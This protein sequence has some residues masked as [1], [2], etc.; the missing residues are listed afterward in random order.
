MPASREAAEAAAAPLA[1]GSCMGAERQKVTE[2]MGPG[3][4]RLRGHGEDCSL[5][6]GRGM[7]HSALCLS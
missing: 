6:N 7:I 4:A 1:E 2:V 3:H 5:W